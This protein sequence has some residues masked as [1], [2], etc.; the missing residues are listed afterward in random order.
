MENQNATKEASEE[1]ARESMKDVWLTPRN[2]SLRSFMLWMGVGV[3]C[4]AFAL[5]ADQTETMRGLIIDAILWGG[6]AFGLMVGT[7]YSLRADDRRAKAKG[8]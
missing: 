6:P 5:Q 4:G 1:N 7:L 3:F 8:V 2:V